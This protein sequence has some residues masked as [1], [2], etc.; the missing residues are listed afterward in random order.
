MGEVAVGATRPKTCRACGN[1]SGQSAA[2]EK[3]E[4]GTADHPWLPVFMMPIDFIR[5]EIAAE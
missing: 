2:E 3:A 1:R 5:A 4:A